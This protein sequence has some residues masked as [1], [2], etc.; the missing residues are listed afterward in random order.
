MGRDRRQGS[1]LRL[2][3]VCDNTEEC[4]VH[5]TFEARV[6]GGEIG[7]VAEGADARPIWGVDY[8]ALGDLP[9]LGFSG[10]GRG[11]QAVPVGR[12]PFTWPP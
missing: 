11:G 8:V 7:A 3:H 10:P 4:V 2:L 6:I 1:S 9:E 5:V 12:P